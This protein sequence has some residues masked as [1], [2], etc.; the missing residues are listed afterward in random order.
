MSNNNTCL[1][2]DSSKYVFNFVMTHQSDHLILEEEIQWMLSKR[3]LIFDS[4]QLAVDYG[5]ET[6][7]EIIKSFQQHGDEFMNKYAPALAHHGVGSRW[8]QYLEWLLKY[9]PLH[10]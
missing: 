7:E 2:T 3:P 1:F 4:N 5:K 6:A 8:K 10:Y 9:V